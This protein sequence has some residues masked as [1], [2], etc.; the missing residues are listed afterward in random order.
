[1][2]WRRKSQSALDTTTLLL[3][4]IL[5]VSTTRVIAPHFIIGSSS[6][7]S[8]VERVGGFF[9]AG[10]WEVGATVE[11]EPDTL[12]LD[13][14][15]ELITVYALIE[16][17][18]DEGDIVVSTVMLDDDIQAEWG[19]V[20]EDGRLMVKFDRTSLISHLEGRVDGEEVE[21]TVSGTF[22]DGVSFSGSDTII[23]IKGGNG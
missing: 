17:I 8:D 23:V 18:Y 3:A 2:S 14:K 6:Y 1:M 12:N 16:T 20:Q 7:L 15:G 11:I 5:T 21:L 22:N 10:I 9:S 4:L 13:S 19:E